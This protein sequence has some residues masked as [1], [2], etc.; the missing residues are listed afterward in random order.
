MSGNKD[1]NFPRNLPGVW[2]KVRITLKSQ[3][4]TCIS[5]SC[6]EYQEP[7]LH[8]NTLH[9]HQRVTISI[10]FHY[11]AYSQYWGY[12]LTT[13]TTPILIGEFGTT[14]A[15]PTDDGWIT[16]LVAYIK[17][18][19]AHFT[20][21]CWY[22]NSMD[23]GGLVKNDW[24]TLESEKDAYLEPIKYPLGGQGGGC[25]AETYD[26]TDINGVPSA[27]TLN[28]S[29][30]AEERDGRAQL[31]ASRGHVSHTIDITSSVFV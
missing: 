30:N 29:V 3:H 8:A 13:N 16:T 6:F 14:L 4:F 28:Y 17:R 1:P 25:A 22:P 21:W 9:H 7:T 27:T 23:T 12:L 10:C 20:F 2:D 31:A 26:T 11:F 15:D 18:N 19:N 5:I 24:L